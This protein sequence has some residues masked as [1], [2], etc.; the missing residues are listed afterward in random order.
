MDEFKFS[1]GI[2][3]RIKR[4]SPFLI[5]DVLKTIPRPRPPVQEVDYGDGVKRQEENPAHPS[6]ELALEEYNQR[7]TELSTRI[8]L[9]RG[10]EADIDYAALSQ[11]KEELAADFGVELEE[12]DDLIAYI[13][14]VATGSPDDVRRLAAAILSE[15]QPSEE[16]IQANVDSFRG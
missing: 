6:Y 12:K 7:V 16:A 1:T 15:S 14:Y 2:V 11:I 8:T 10:V 5:S 4:V 9:R 13:K 3:V